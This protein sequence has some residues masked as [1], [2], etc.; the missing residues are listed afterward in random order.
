M[1]K[2]GDNFFYEDEV[3]MI[4]SKSGLIKYGLVLTT[5]RTR[6]EIELKK[7]TY[8][9]PNEIKVIW[10]PTGIEEVITDDKVCAFVINF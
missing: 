7:S 1:D 6:S 9:S 3:A 5:N 2:D 4:S 8:R 10:H